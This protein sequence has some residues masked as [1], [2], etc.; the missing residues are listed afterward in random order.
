MKTGFEV[1]REVMVEGYKPSIA[2]LYDP[3]DGGMSF[4]H[5]AAPDKCVMIF[6]AEGPAGI[7]DATEKG[8]KEIVARHDECKAVDPKY[9]EKW[10][11][12][13][14]WGAEQIA[15]E[16]QEILETQ[17]I[18]ITTE[19]SGCWNCI[20]EIYETARKRIMAE[21]PDITMVG[22]HSSHSYI[23]GTNMYF[24]YY[25]NIVDCPPEEEINKYHNLINKIIVEQVVKYGG[26]IAHHH[27]GQ[28]P[29]R[30]YLYHLRH[31]Q[32]A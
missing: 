26:S 18:G 28:R 1:L 16:R 32:T 4:S 11:D 21:V 23:N 25:Y 27:D 2:R 17:N 30:G 10:F 8:I 5:F 12:G 22:G 6:M 15:Q 9:I 31:C 7:T 29:V 14:N 19:V 3:A 20:Y 24:V 13:L